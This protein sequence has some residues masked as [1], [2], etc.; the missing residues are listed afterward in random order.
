MA[1]PSDRSGRYGEHWGQQFLG[2][3]FDRDDRLSPSF[4]ECV[5]WAFPLLKHLT[6]QDVKNAVNNDG[7]KSFIPIKG[8]TAL[9]E[10]VADI[11]L[12]E[13]WG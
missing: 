12:P 11:C 3:P 1:R 4:P 2:Y 8:R 5:H 13:R 9:G 7:V 6:D 10:W